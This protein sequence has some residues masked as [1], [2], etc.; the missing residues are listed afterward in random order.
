MSRLRKKKE[1]RT[2]F[3]MTELLTRMLADGSNLLRHAWIFKHH[4]HSCSCLLCRHQD[5]GVR[6]MM[7]R[8]LITPPTSSDL[9]LLHSKSTAIRFYSSSHRIDQERQFWYQLHNYLGYEDSLISMCVPKWDVVVLV[10]NNSLI[11]DSFLDNSFVSAK[12]VVVL[13]DCVCEQNPSNYI[14]IQYS[15]LTVLLD[16]I[17]HLLFLTKH[18]LRIMDICKTFPCIHVRTSVDSTNCVFL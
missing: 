6:V 3:T 12:Q 16:M 8:T 4:N 17:L 13:T 15:S 7:P 14:C 5:K 18:R 1:N 10:K 9:E 2:F 11:N